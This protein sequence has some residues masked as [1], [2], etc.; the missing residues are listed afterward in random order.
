M[1]QKNGAIVNA[2]CDRAQLKFA[3]LV[4]TRYNI[5]TFFAGNSAAH[6]YRRLG[7]LTAE[8][9]FRNSQGQEKGRHEGY[10]VRQSCASIRGTDGKSWSTNLLCV[11]MQANEN[12]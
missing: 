10:A 12:L 1:W 4:H 7:R 5:K 2:N 11:R 3:F 9:L 6:R 8:L